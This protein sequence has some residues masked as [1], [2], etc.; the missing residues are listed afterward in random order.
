LSTSKPGFNSRETLTFVTITGLLAL[1]PISTD[2]Y[3]PAITAMSGE[4]DA[5]VSEGQLTLSIFMIGVAIGQLFFGPLSDTFGR[6]PVVRAGCFAFIAF[7]FLNSLAWSIESMWIGRIFQGATAA[8]GAVIA[9]AMIRDVYEGD[10]AAQ[11]MAL[12]SASM[13]S[14]PLFAP[15]LGALITVEL[16]WRFTF[17]AQAIFAAA[18]LLGLAYFQETVKRI[19]AEPHQQL[20]LS[21]V[22]LSFRQCLTNPLFVGYQLSGTFSFC[23]VFVY[24]STV[25]F[26]LRDVFDVSTEF[27][28]VIFAMTAAGFI[29]GSL[30]SSRLVLKWGA[31]RTLRR[32][33]F[34]CAVSTTAALL[35]LVNPE[36]TKALLACISIL[37]FFGVGLIAPNASMGAVSLYPHK[38]GAASAVYGSV[39]SVASAIVGAI[40]GATYSGRM[41]EPISIMFICSLGALIGIAITRHHRTRLI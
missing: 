31:D 41:L 2:L 27:F 28:G 24:I 16:G 6:L 37:F 39:H 4:L 36:A 20:R 35:T 26:F 21:D 33:A 40:A 29:V 5:T 15:T 19:K 3:L 11:I 18:V 13:A 1:I 23:G 38:A 10:R 8:S 14:V 34:I 32:G 25:A 17:I 7:S 30:S 22:F 12:T 9:R